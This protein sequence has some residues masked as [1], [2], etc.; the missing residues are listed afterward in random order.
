MISASLLAAQA[1]SSA[2]REWLTCR[3]LFV[4]ELALPFWGACA[5]NARA[6]AVAG[7]VAVACD[8]FNSVA[9]RKWVYEK[10]SLKIG[11]RR[12]RAL[13]YPGAGAGLRRAKAEG[14]Q[15]GRPRKAPPQPRRRAV[16]VAERWSS[17]EGSS[18]LR[19]DA[20]RLRRAEPLAIVC[21]SKMWPRSVSANSSLVVRHVVPWRLVRTSVSNVR[22]K[23][24]T[25][26]FRFTS[27][28]KG[29]SLNGAR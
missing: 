10:S 16:Q 12:V 15:L 29:I 26:Y 2:P 9:T 6:R 27:G 7:A 1:Q 4:F 8:K 11:L 28:N 20:R 3:H 14:K 23:S 18:W 22:R 24:A 5:A 19:L 13:D 25:R 17:S 21:R